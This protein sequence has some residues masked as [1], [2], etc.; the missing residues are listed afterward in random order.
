MEPASVPQK[1]IA[2]IDV[3]K[4]IGILLVVAAHNDLI[5]VSP[6]LHRWIYSFHMP[7]FFFLSGYFFKPAISF[8]V[9]FKKRFN[10]LLKP[11][12][13]TVLLI[14]GTSVS[15]GKMSFETALRRMAKFAYGSGY[16][17]DW[18]QLWFIPHLFLLSF[19]ALL[20][21]TIFKPEKNH[22][23]R[24]LVLLGL[25]AL[26]VY[27]IATFWE[28]P[29]RLFGKEYVLYGLPFSADLLPVSGFF[30]ILGNEVRRLLKSDFFEKVWVVVISGLALLAS[31]YFLVDFID[32]N[33]RF[34]PDWFVSTLEALLGILFVFSLSTH[35]AKRTKRLSSV[36]QYVGNAS[37][38]ILI[39]HVPIQGFLGE[40]I[41]AVG[42][43]VGLSIALAFVLGVLIS[44][45]IYELFFR[46]N[47]TALWWF[48]RTVS[49][50]VN[51]SS[52]SGGSERGESP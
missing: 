1:R 21:Y 25:Q 26:G 52:S 17:L 9:L 42:G 4:G 51:N 19:Y 13:F 10:T 14:Y 8:G 34:Y 22:W 18:V 33:I 5:L 31:N 40:K 38:F 28:Y 49:K 50:P 2:Y 7:L 15:F 47:P 44:L 20:F 3:A 24:I 6:F 39:F 32:L 48:G 36:L 29:I 41:Q 27:A 43:S 45:L 30:F 37:L 23:L 12:I 46:N 16:Y 35:I 11:Y